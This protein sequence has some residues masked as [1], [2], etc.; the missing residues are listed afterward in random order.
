MARVGLT[1]KG[2]FLRGDRDLQLVILCSDRPTCS[3]LTQV[4]REFSQQLNQVLH[5]IVQQLMHCPHSSEQCL[6]QF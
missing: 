3:L 1:A 6:V 5:C 2:L 4:V